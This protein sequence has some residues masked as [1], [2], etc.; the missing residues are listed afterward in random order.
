LKLASRDPARSI[1]EI[2]DV[3]RISREAL[4]EVRRAVTGYGSSTLADEIR[5]ARTALESAGAVLDCEI[6]PVR[7]SVAEEQVLALSIREAV[8]N[9]IRHAHARRCEIRLAAAGAG[10]RLEVRDDGKGGTAPEGSG[11]LGMRARVAELGGR[12]EREGRDGTRLTIT[13]P[14]TAPDDEPDRRQVAEAS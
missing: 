2:R 6:A 7:L 12:L 11:L 9:V 4:A 8:T 14:L 10:V 13:L 1:A 3:E 5:H